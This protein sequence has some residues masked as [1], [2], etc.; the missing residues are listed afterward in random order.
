VRDVQKVRL[1]SVPLV[2]A[3]ITGAWAGFVPGLFIGAIAGTLLT[4][5]AG[6]ALEWMREL[7][8]TTGIEQQLLPF[9]NRIGLL[10]TLQDGWPVV[11]PLAAIALGLFSALIGTLTAAL[12]AMTLRTVVRG[13]EFETESVTPPAPKVVERPQEYRRAAGDS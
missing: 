10:Q 5:G 8:F 4:F 1:S 3:L 9:G 7:S 11:I 12:V 6:A 13:V 2:P